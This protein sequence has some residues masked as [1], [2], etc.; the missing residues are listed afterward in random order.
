MRSARPIRSLVI[1]EAG[2]EDAARH[3]F[4]WGADAVWGD[5]EEYV[6]PSQLIDARRRQR[7]LIDSL[8]SEGRT[9]LT[10]VHAIRNQEEMLKDLDAILSPALYGVLIPKTELGDITAVTDVL[11][12]LERERDIEVGHTKLFP[13]IESA[14]GIAD[15]YQIAKESDRIAHMG[16]CTSKGGDPARSIGYRWTPGGS[17]TLYMRSRVL[18]A[19][20]AAQVPHPIGGGYHR[21]ADSFDQHID[22]LRTW[23]TL[24]RDLGL[25]GMH[26]PTEEA[27][28]AAVNDVFTPS[29]EEIAMWQEM[30]DAE[31]RAAA[32]GRAIDPSPARY[33]AVQLEYVRSLPQRSA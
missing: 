5:L 33:A 9:V 25:L 26:C 22:D 6:H 14:S 32:M 29:A 28:I 12:Q 4:A 2:D 8:G 13:L 18:M 11:A 21:V 1:V 3:A 30:V 17:E 16:W 19:A 23:A 31:A 24:Q 20:R 7:A 10:R 15:V 27:S